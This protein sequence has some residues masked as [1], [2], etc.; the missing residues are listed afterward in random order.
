MALISTLGLRPTRRML[1]GA[2]ALPLAAAPDGADDGADAPAPLPDV[3]GAAPAGTAVKGGADV[4]LVTKEFPAWKTKYGELKVSATLKF[5]AEVKAGEGNGGFAGSVTS[6]DKSDGRTV[7]TK[8]SFNYADIADRELFGG[9]SLND[10]SIGFE[11]EISGLDVTISGTLKFTLATNV[12]NA[13]AQAKLTLLNIKGAKEIAG[14]AIEFKI[15]PVAFERVIAG[16][17]TKVS[18]EYKAAFTVDAKKVG[19]EV[20]KKV[21]EKVAKDVLE[22]EAKKQGVKVLGRS[23]AETVL[24]DLGPLAAAFGV[25]LDIGALLNQ[26]TAAPGAAK[27]VIDEIL[28][29]LAERYHEKD[30]LGKMW[31]ISKNSP[32]ILAAL[33]AGGVIGTMAGVGDL[34][35]FKLFGLDKLGD[36]AASLKA[37]GQGLTEL[38][39]VA[40]LPLQTLAGAILHRALEIGVKFNPKHA[41]AHHGALEPLVAGVWNR[42]RPLYRTRGGLDQL[43]AV[44]F[45]DCSPDAAKLLAL[46]DF[47]LRHQ[48]NS[49]G[50][51]VNLSSPERLAESLRA[52]SLSDL[53]RFLEGNNL[54]R[55]N[56]TLDPNLDPDA[57][58]P[59]LLDELYG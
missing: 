50:V 31:L 33:V 21:L 35:L 7:G 10:F 1:A 46:C 25:G 2:G 54:M 45:K 48:A 24:K 12:F 20:G 27:F 44:R 15:A 52:L 37:F 57:I 34:V 41:I 29:D 49:A 4:E 39:Q 26:Y 40:K 9:W 11:S 58:D 19:L 38:A 16:V 32:R 55:C 59:A 42:I 23:V 30:T 56:V 53:L 17:K 28:G 18:V 51:A 13:P 8:K 6:K 22:K 47:A 14:P 36:Y 43:L 5:Q 3:A